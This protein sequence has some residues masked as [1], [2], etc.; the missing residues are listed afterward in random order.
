MIDFFR[1]SL[2]RKLILLLTSVAA[3]CVLAS[4]IGLF[5]YQWRHASR[6]LYEESHAQAQLLANSSSA[7]L[8]FNDERAANETLAS[9]RGE[10]RITLACLFDRGGNVVGSYNPLGQA[11]TCPANWNLSPLPSHKTLQVVQPIDVRGEAV[12]T[13]VLQVSLS[14]LDH[15]RTRFIQVAA[16]T[17]FGAILLAM[18]LSSVM[19]RWISRPIL[20]LTEVAIKVSRDGEYSVRASHTAQDEV[21]LLIDQFNE[22]LARVQER[23]GELRLSHELLE[24]K[25]EER[26]RDLDQARRLAEQSNQA[27]SS[28][29]ANMSHELRTPLNAIIGYSEMLSE[30]AAADGNKEA[31]EDLEKVLSSARHLRGIISDVLDLSKIEAGQMS[32]FLEPSSANALLHDVSATAEVLSRKGGNKL[33]LKPLPDDC[34]IQVDPL[35]FRQCLLN[36]ISNACKFTINGGVSISVESQATSKGKDL[37][38][39]VQDTGP[40][41]AEAD[42]QKLFKN[43]SQVDSSATRKFG[44]TGLGLAISQEL[45]RAMGG[46][47]DVQSTLHV[48]STFSIHIPQAA[49]AA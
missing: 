31:A 32:I 14:E 40:G 24:H 47:I 35:R 28:F 11:I 49:S 15:L 1:H 23:D 5:W 44:G 46:Y 30:D 33:S 8:A 18:L 7:A 36:L 26:T 43:F 45:C 21:G 38:W 6:A 22:M 41:I 4:C 27:K 9:I 37:V 29:L 20:Q 19:E 10:R 17:A 48:G 42:L 25:V 16:G 12:G 39:S 3:V 13:L 34:E 2:R